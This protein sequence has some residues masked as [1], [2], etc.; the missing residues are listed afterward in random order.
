MHSLNYLELRVAITGHFSLGT[1]ASNTILYF[2][3]YGLG[4]IKIHSLTH[5]PGFNKAKL[6]SD[7]FSD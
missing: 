6:G 5:D 2:Y 3:K 4:L 7:C 1:P